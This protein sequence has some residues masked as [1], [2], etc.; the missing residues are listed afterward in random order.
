MKNQAFQ[1]DFTPKEL[2]Y[3][4]FGKKKCPHCGGKLIKHKGFELTDG[5]QYVSQ[6][7]YFFPKNAVVKHYLYFYDCEK[8]SCRFTLYELANGRKDVLL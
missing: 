4:L 6:R 1:Y 3:F 5:S 7:G 2:Q 8:C